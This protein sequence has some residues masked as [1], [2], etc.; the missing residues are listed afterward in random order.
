MVTVNGYEVSG[1][2]IS[3]KD[4]GDRLLHMPLSDHQHIVVC[5]GEELDRWVEAV[6]PFAQGERHLDHLRV[7]D[8]CGQATGAGPGR[9]AAEQIAAAEHGWV[10]A[11]GSA[12]CAT[13]VQEAGALALRAGA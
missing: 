10:V 12:H 9:L 6:Y 3:V 8:A 11:G 5:L 7:C 13:C 4:W 2:L 1:V